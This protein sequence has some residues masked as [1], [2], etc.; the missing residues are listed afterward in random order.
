LSFIPSKF[1]QGIFD[2]IAGGQGNA[3]IEA[4]AGSGKTTT[5]LQSLGLIDPRNEVVFLAFNTKIAKELAAKVPGHVKAMTFNGLGHRA[6]MKALGNVGLN[7]DKL[8]G[9]WFKMREA[10]EINEGDFKYMSYPVKRLVDL[11]RSVGIVPNNLKAELKLISLT[12]DTDE[13]WM[14]LIEEYELTQGT[15]QMSDDLIFQANMKLV[16]FSR[17]VLRRAI[18][19][20]SEIDFGDQLYLP[21]IFNWP[22]PQYDYVFVDEAQDVSLIQRIMLSKCLKQSG[23]LVAVGDPYQAIYGFRGADFHAL[24][25]IAKLFNCKSLPLSICYRCAKSV[26]RE[27]QRVVPHIEHHESSPE[28]EIVELG[29]Y[30]NVQFDSKSNDMIICRANV[31]L[32]RLAYSLIGRKIPCKIVGRDIGK[33]LSTLIR[34]FRAY[35]IEDLE[36]KLNAWKDKEITKL[37]SKDPDADTSKI[38]DKFDAIMVFIDSCGANTVDELLRSIES[39]FEDGKRDGYVTLSTIH[40]AKGLE[41]D[42]VYILDRWMLPKFEGATTRAGLDQNTNCLYVAITR[43]KKQLMY[44]ETPKG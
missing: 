17:E 27:A 36:N 8:A 42:R 7:A 24:S 26:V 9:I 13:I 39:L 2:F 1:Q 43:A 18:L 40:K 38:D 23:R 10:N 41:A 29:D 37:L 22:F 34:K 30:R 31:P 4:V 33:N 11:A 19:L 3:I 15:P 14:A 12:E 28:G 44:I 21:V 32:I 25:N 20:R 5:I 35:S 6:C 16:N